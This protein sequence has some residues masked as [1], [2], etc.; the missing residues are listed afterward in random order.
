MEAATKRHIKSGREYDYLFPAAKM[1]TTTVRRDAKLEDTMHFIPKVVAQT[2]DHTTGITQRLKA[3]DVYSTCRNIWEFIYQHIAYNKDR[4]GYE[5]IRS[6]RRTWRDRRSGVDCDCYSTFISSILTNLR[7]PHKLRI[8]KYKADHFQHIYPV[9]PFGG[10]DIIIDC[11]TDRFDYEV[12]YSAKKD[13]TMELQYLDGLHGAGL[14]ERGNDLVFEGNEDE[15]GALG[16]FGFLKK[17]VKAINKVNPVTVLLRNGFLAA[18]KLNLF[19]VASRIKYAYLSPDEAIKRGI[20]KDKYD[21]LVKIKNKLESIFSTAGGNP[22]N[23]KKAILKGK[24]NK[25]KEVA[26]SGLGFLDSD[27]SVMYMDSNTP[28]AQLLGPD[29][30]YDENVRGMEGFEGLGSLGALG[31]LGAAPFVAAAAAAVG[32]IAKLLKGVGNIFGG[33][34]KGSEDFSESETAAADKEVAQTPAAATATPSLTT[35]TSSGDN[36]DADSSTADTSTATAR[37]ASSVADSSDTSTETAVAPVTSTAESSLVPA[38]T[39]V[40][41]SSAGAAAGT[42]EGFWQKNKKWLVP[43]MI[44]VGGIAVIAIGMKL[45]KPAPKGTANLN[46]PPKRNHDRKAGKDKKKPVALL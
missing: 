24:G 20:I 29:I 16:K 11:V 2:L 18:M 33:G 43:T 13:I 8:T 31:E 27:A 39:A 21:K 26:V 41:A 15:V 7:I 34:Q 38:A 40:A 19:K 45:M 37:T 5:Q 35:A 46:G 28:L 44:G 3:E 6:P 4:Y 17:I 42:Q 9:V 23:L 10:R 30:F 12:P 32:M 1:E 25:N 14:G 22:K 36:S